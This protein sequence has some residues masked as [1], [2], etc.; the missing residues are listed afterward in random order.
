MCL[1]EGKRILDER[2]IR[3]RKYQK[4]Y[5][6]ADS[7]ETASTLCSLAVKAGARIFNLMSVED[8]MVRE[9]RVIGVVLNW[10]AVEMAQ[11]HVDPL[12]VR[13]KYVVDATGHATEVARVIERKVGAHLTTD[14]GGVLGEKSL[15][16]EVSEETTLENTGEIYPGVFVA[17]MAANA[18]FGSYRMGPI[19]GG[20]LLS[21]EKVAKL[22]LKELK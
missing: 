20:M 4:G 14:T 19:F 13:A 2:S 12:C 3:S 5:Y 11:L 15:W 8:V 18:A 10:T 9:G 7:V 21:G 6:T 17:G 1:E 16:S 22:I